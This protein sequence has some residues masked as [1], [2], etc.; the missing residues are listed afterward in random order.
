MSISTAI[1][2]DRI[3][4]IVGYKLRAGNF[5]TGT[6]NLPQRIAI[7]AEANTANQA[8]IDDAPFEFI[9]AKEVGD[10][11][12]YGSPAY[13]IARILRPIS[14][15]LVGGIPTV[16][17][18]QLAAGGATSAVYK[19]GVTVAT[20]VTANVTHKV[21]INGRDNIDGFSFSFSP[22]IGDDA[23]A[24]R[25][26]IIDAINNVLAA[27]VIAAEN[28]TD[29]DLT[30]KWAGATA[31]LS[32][33]IDTGDNAGGIVYAETSNTDGTGEPAITTSLGYFG[34][35][36][37]TLV[38]N[39]YGTGKLADLEAFNGVPD[40]DN[41]TGRY[42]PTNFKPF[43]A[44]FGSL[45]SDKDDI[46]LITDAA[47][48]KDQVT[49]VLCPAPNSEGFAFE[50]AANMCVTCALIF[51]DNPH[52]GNGGV[53]YNDMPVPA[54]SDI[55]DFESYDGRDFIAK[56]GSS[57]VLLE[58]G[59][60]TVQDY[61]TTYHP[62]GETPAKFRKVRDLNVNWNIAFGW[63]IIQKSD[64]WDKAIT[65][66]DAPVR[67]GDTVSPKRVKQ[68]V[69]SY[70]DDLTDRAL[71]AD[72]DFTR[73]ST[74]VGINEDNPA[75]LDTFFRVKLTSTADIISSDVEFDFN[76]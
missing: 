2:L 38:I 76:F 42:L 23:A 11:Y 17:Y 22:A 30:S 29:V 70:A 63:N 13:M 6:P 14:G 57:T 27:P 54:D 5:G 64:I 61:E 67:V 9:N 19:L 55:G 69:S 40:P 36:W 25:Q 7:L 37:N 56:A 48:R 75:R 3:S 74:Q 51:N 72:P 18:P 8:T 58:N 73:E 41:P 33:R 65:D 20:T 71:I 46:A 4:R 28:V 35:T 47:A 68:L 15:S 10:K 53:S 34:E 16:L 32:V 43:V 21:V 12:G 1:S 31:I 49:N 60:F 50:A 39:S 24:V 44:L 62:D 45:L 59:K 52:L 66:D 26:K